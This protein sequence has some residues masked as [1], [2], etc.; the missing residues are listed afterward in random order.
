MENGLYCQ[1]LRLKDMALKFDGTLILST[2][3]SVKVLSFEKYTQELWDEMYSNLLKEFMQIDAR[4]EFNVL[5][6][7][8]CNR[9]TNKC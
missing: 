9:I 7:N 8:I 6:L 3:T 2:F 5:M 4:H 1:C